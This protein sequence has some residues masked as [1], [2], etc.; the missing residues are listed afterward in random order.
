MHSRYGSSPVHE[1]LA[2][3]R[4]TPLTADA[5]RLHDEQ[6]QTKVRQ[7]HCQDCNSSWW[8]LAP[9][10]KPV[11]RCK[12]CHKRF[13]AIARGCE[14]GVGRFTCPNSDCRNV[15]YAQCSEGNARRECIKCSTMAERPYIHPRHKKRT[16]SSRI[17]F[18][19]FA[20]KHH[21]STGSTQDTW[22]T[23][24][25]SLATDQPPPRY[26]TLPPPC[27]P[28]LFGVSPPVGD[29]E[30]IRSLSRSPVTRTS[31]KLVCNLKSSVQESR[32]SGRSYSGY[33]S[34]VLRRPGSSSS[35]YAM[36]DYEPPV[37][38]P[39]RLRRPGSFFSGYAMPDYEPP[40]QEP[41]RLR[42]PGSS[43]SGYAMPDY[44]PPVQEPRRLRL[45][46]SSSSGYAMPDYEPPVQEPRRL[47]RPG[48]SY[49]G[50]AMP[51][52]EP[53]VQEPRRL[54]L[55]G[56]SSSGYAMP[57]YEPPVQE[58]RRLRRP[59]SSYSGYAM[60]DYE[61][62]VQEP[63]RLRL[64]GSSY[65]GYAMPDYE[66]PVQEPRRLRRSGSFCSGYAMPDYESFV[67]EPR[68][69]RR[70]GSSY[71]VRNVRYTAPSSHG[72]RGGYGSDHSSIGSTCLTR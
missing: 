42:R 43:Y 33:K 23:Q 72:S 10:N 30:P 29:A 12:K 69:L 61:L 19:I 14:F 68:Y 58:P 7:F 18:Y 67:Q 70:S 54:R 27:S 45:S 24:P 52:Y 64:P 53:P 62:P 41:R 32:C 57:D 8:M 9:A 17:Y 2:E 48:S 21:F 22:L 36:P 6:M 55:S 66:L 15:F 25:A 37:Q 49:S 35:G 38:K 34:P 40:V 51:D 44:E 28:L 16:T 20:S 59:G 50:Y 5:L 1:T 60:P 4:P 39:R 3:P 65:S 71:S 26:D 11:S 13:D 56:S 63:R 46:G 31:L 47:R